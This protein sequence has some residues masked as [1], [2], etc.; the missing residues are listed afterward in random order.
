MGNELDLLLKDFYIEKGNEKYLY[1]LDEIKKIARQKAE[2]MKRN[3]SLVKRMK[4]LFGSNQT[5]LDLYEEYAPHYKE[6]INTSKSVLE[7][8][9]H[10]TELL[11]K[12][13]ILRHI[14]DARMTQLE[15]DYKKVD[16][17]YFTYCREYVDESL[18][19]PFEME[20]WR[21]VKD[22]LRVL[23]HRG[24]DISQ[25]QKKL[26]DYEALQQFECELKKA[27][28]DALFE[29]EKLK[30]LGKQYKAAI[31]PYKLG[32]EYIDYL[33]RIKTLVNE[34]YT[35]I[36]Q[37]LERKIRREQEKEAPSAK[38]LISLMR[39]FDNVGDDFEELVP[40]IRS[41][42]YDNEIYVIESLLRTIQAS[43]NSESGI[44]Q[45]ILKISDS[46]KLIKE[47][48][49]H[50]LSIE[51]VLGT[52]S[53]IYREIENDYDSLRNLKARY[54][55]QLL[56]AYLNHFESLYEIK[57]K[58]INDWD[59]F[60]RII[61]TL[62]NIS[63]ALNGSIPQEAHNKLSDAKQIYLGQCRDFIKKMV[64][65]AKAS[66]SLN[67][68]ELKY[69]GIKDVAPKLKNWNLMPDLSELQQ[70][71]N[72][73]LQYQNK[74]LEAERELDSW[75]QA[76]DTK[77]MSAAAA[78]YMKT[79]EFLKRPY[80][81]YFARF[82][83]A[84]LTVVRL[85]ERYRRLM[86]EGESLL[87]AYAHTG[88]LIVHFPAANVYMVFIEAES[89]TFGRKDSPPRNKGDFYQN[90]RIEIPWSSVS[91]Q[92]GTLDLKSWIYTDNNSSFG[93]YSAGSRTPK[94]S[95]DVK[96][97]GDLNFSKKL[98]FKFSFAEAFTVFYLENVHYL[99][100]DEVKFYS[101]WREFLQ[102]WSKIYFIKLHGDGGV[103]LSRYDVKP[104]ADFPDQINS[105]YIEKKGGRYFASD[106]F[107]QI[108]NVPVHIGSKE[109]K[110]M[111]FFP[112]IK[113]LEQ[114]E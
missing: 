37:E 47:L 55:K 64:D 32:G 95:I 9:R 48:Q 114:Q 75:Q 68:F 83:D 54:E 49:T 74:A 110:E 76:V 53:I 27:L 98:T 105:F 50:I 17:K 81:E 51:S 63:N 109:L 8:A 4:H 65:E 79:T 52:I 22:A 66:E 70:M 38:L 102:D 67:D 3:R 34:A 26:R 84:R 41:N 111:E 13:T 43:A 100:D 97:D 99:R 86:E 1:D 92:H 16:E 107:N 23:H 103:Y 80:P 10:T 108:T 88:E 62:Q 7:K 104:Y 89:I 29:P 56:E 61:I 31:S 42:K 71:E 82:A 19:S 72:D 60:H 36:S 96:Q 46:T 77:N 113:P 101:G 18:A 93:S 2:E 6:K 45:Q 35:I 91:G 28:S 25:M 24:I 58:Q 14:A 44:A 69:Q 90:G 33:L 5:V 11:I 40:E 15:D 85:G 73:T 20:N 112:V 94:K 12:F 57:Q 39:D 59:E 30:S 78:D 106:F 21:H 87:K